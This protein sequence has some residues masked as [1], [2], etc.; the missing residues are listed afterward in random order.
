[1]K[2]NAFPTFIRHATT[3]LSIWLAV[4]C[5]CHS[6]ETANWPQW[7]GPTGNG[8][9]M[10]AKPPREWS[11]TENVRW[12]TALP[13]K[14]H[15]T[16]IVWGDRIFVTTAI[17]AGT[18]LKPRMSGRPGEHDNLPI[19]TAYDFSVIAIDRKSGEIL[20]QR[21]VHHELPLEA[22][23]VT[24]SM[25][26]A[27]PVTDEELV[28]AYFGSYGLHCLDPKGNI[29]WSKD[30]GTMHSKHG[31]GEGSSPALY[32]DTIF[33]NWDH[34]EGSFVVAINKFTGEERWRTTRT[35]DTSWS[36]PIVVLN[37]SLPQLVVCGTNRV[38]GYDANE[39]KLVWE[40][41]GMSSNV[42]ATPVYSNGILYVGSSYE[43]RILMA[44]NIRGAVGN[45]TDSSRVKWSRTRGTPYVPSLLLYEEALYFLTHYQNMLTRV[46][47]PT[48]KD[49]PG[50]F[51][52]GG[53]GNIYSSPIA[54]DGHIYVTD[55]Q[56]TTA[57]ITHSEVPRV[58]ALNRIDETVSAS[59][60][61]VNDELF[62]RSETHLFCIREIKP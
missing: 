21:V 58:I 17:A 14:G 5:L 2:K 35:E 8:I 43:K 20:W 32:G 18:K 7:R 62:I 34:E 52:V 3:T 13:G 41:G 26:S 47:G 4:S 10:S 46:D 55:L 31:H 27:S 12:K 25:A 1:M 57:V 61:A 59:L 6:D 37:D 33:I 49:A 28:F 44:M 54:A 39:G 50:V 19:D 22:G 9:S 60:V 53:L 48:G 15:S 29:R 24:G 23:H 16:P 36:S 45:F 42:V 30:F 51:R 40:C 11:K 38:C 56:G